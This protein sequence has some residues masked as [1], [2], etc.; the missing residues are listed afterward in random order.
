MKES[1]LRCFCS[2][3]PL[4]ATY[5]IDEEE[6]LYVHVLAWKQNRLIADVKVT[7]GDVRLRC[8]NCMRYH[9]VRIHGK[10]ARLT[11]VNDE[12]QASNPVRAYT[13]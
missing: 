2:T 10:I 8:R 7:G 3:H 11:P 1:E 6:H 4:L 13:G 12:A 9:K 5:G